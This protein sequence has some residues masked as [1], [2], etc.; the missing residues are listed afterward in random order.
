MRAQLLSLAWAEVQQQGHVLDT[1]RQRLLA[2]GV[3]STQLEQYLNI[4]GAN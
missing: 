3:T 4:V 2:Y 1:T